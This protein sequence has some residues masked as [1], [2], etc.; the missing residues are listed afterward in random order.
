MTAG[1]RCVACGSGLTP[2]PG[3]YDP[4]TSRAFT[5]VGCVACGTRHV[6]GV[7]ASEIPGFYPSDYYAY[8]D[9]GGGVFAR[10]R[11]RLIDAR[12]RQR[13]SDRILR[14]LAAGMVPGVPPPAPRPGARL[15][16]VGCGAGERTEPFERLGW[17]LHGTELDPVAAARAASR[18][19]AMHAH[20]LGD[21]EPG[22]I[23]CVRL[24]HSLEH[25]LDPRAMLDRC[26]RVLEPGGRMIIGI[27]NSSGLPARL[28][29]VQWH[30][31]DAPRHLV[32][33]TR[34]GLERL[35]DETG[36]DITSATTY[37]DRGIV[38]SLERLAV[39]TGRPVAFKDRA[40]LILLELPVNLVLRWSGRG[41]LLEVH[42][43]PRATEA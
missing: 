7:E 17:E 26:R 43:I 10:L 1:V 22:S 15:L 33:F 20:D 42:A 28:F 29:G 5:L 23:A 34:G 35:L 4:V 21:V 12:A 9:D 19:L 30:H 13:W 8:A 2:L 41:D 27:P 6:T 25:F 40:P 39:A 11:T 3:V 36:F 24:W 31:F 37:G 14:R 16:D 32:H 38:G 18:G